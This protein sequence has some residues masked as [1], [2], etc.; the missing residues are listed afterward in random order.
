[1]HE[2]TGF[3]RDILFV[4]K[5]LK[6]ASGQEIKDELEKTQGRSVHHARLYTNLDALVDQG[7]VSKGKSDGR[8]NRYTLTPSGEREVMDRFQW[9]Q[10]YL[11]VA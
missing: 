10:A 5:G 6:A 2:L 3:Q 9:E 7:L 8:T 1:M 11:E 4:V